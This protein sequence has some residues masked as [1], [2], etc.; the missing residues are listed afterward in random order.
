MSPATLN[1]ELACLKH[2]FNKAIEWE[3]MEY[4]PV[5]RVKLLREDNAR[6]RY[7]TCD[8]IRRLYENCTEHLKSIVL[9]ALHTGMR[10]G[11]ILKLKWEDVDLDQKIVFVKNTKITRSERFL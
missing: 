8:E 6:L 9:T 7:L 11:E 3:K 5:R 4:N 2:M 10:R 1:R